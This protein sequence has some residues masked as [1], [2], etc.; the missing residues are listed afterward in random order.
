MSHT[1]STPNYNL[2]QFLT[3]DKPFWLTDINGAFLAIDT[4]IDA[5][6][7]AADNAQ[8]DA[9]QALTDAGNATTAAAAA[10]GK[11]SGAVAS[12]SDAFDATAT[13]SVGDYVMYNNLLYVCTVAITTPGPWT[14]SAN[15]SRT[16]IESIVN[17]KVSAIE[18]TLADKPTSTFVGWGSTIT[19]D[20][21]SRSQFLVIAG[22][23]ELFIVWFP[24][25]H[26]VNVLNLRTGN[27]Q[28]GTDTA[29]L[30]GYTFVRTNDGDGNKRLTITTTGSIAYTV[31]R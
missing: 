26:D 11:G 18:A 12:I 7:D 20:Y 1:N 24:S 13:Y 14:G 30:D 17:D 21:G 3:T 6:K 15:W 27:S 4:G 19:T 31:I 29:T 2:P 5:A 23:A 22:A 16:T 8:N 10:D 28:T 25:T 9:T